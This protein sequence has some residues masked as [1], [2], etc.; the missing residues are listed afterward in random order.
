MFNSD[1]L[2]RVYA[3]VERR[4]AG[5][6]EF[7]RLAASAEAQVEG[8]VSD[9]YSRHREPDAGASAGKQAYGR[10][11]QLDCGNEIG[12][13]FDDISPASA[14]KQGQSRYCYDTDGFHCN[15]QI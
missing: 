6:P 13:H 8:E 1:Y 12:S 9:R 15:T 5:E 14:Q 2:N 7:P 3:E 10:S 4:D 11:R